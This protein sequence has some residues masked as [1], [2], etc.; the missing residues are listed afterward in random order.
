MG[1]SNLLA[2]IRPKT[3]EGQIVSDAD[4]CTLGGATAI[5]RILR[6]GEKIGRPIF[7]KSIFPRLY[8]IDAEEYK[9]RNNTDINHFFEKLLRLRGLLFTKTARDIATPGHEFMIQF[10]RNYFAEN[11]V[12]E[13]TEFLDK[14]TA[15]LLR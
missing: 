7:D 12:P 15:E 13:W 5:C 3:L 4:M 1:Y 6:Y 14:Y 8:D 2:G 10:L 11:N 9:K